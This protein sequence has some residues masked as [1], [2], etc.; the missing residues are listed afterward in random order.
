VEP[1]EITTDVFE[2]LP[3]KAAGAVVGHPEFRFRC[4]GC[5]NCCKGPGSVFFTANDLSQFYDHLKLDAAGRKRLRERIIQARDNGY[6][7]HR[8]TGACHFLDSLNHCTVYPVRPLQCRTFPFWP[9]TFASRA[10]FQFVLEGCPGTM[11]AHDRGDPQATFSLLATVRKV[12]Q[13]RREFLQP[14]TGAARR[15]MI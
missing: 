13:T 11:A 15:F 1:G 7:V 9:S 3:V 10:D 4:T 5:G 2:D 14:Q 12:N 6:Y 8:T